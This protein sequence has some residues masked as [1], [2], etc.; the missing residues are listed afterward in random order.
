MDCLVI[1]TPRSTKGLVRELNIPGGIIVAKPDGFPYSERERLIF[2]VVRVK[3]DKRLEH[4]DP[5][6]YVFLKGPRIRDRFLSWT[7]LVPVPNDWWHDLETQL[8]RVAGIEDEAKRQAAIAAVWKKWEK[9]I[10]R[11]EVVRVCRYRV[12]NGKVVETT[13]AK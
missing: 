8:S 12:V 11:R 13:S 10:G 7:G 3:D 5:Y 2:D 9:R 6:H 1:K 4:L